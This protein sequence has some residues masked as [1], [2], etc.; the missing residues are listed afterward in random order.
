[1]STSE[2]SECGKVVSS[3]FTECG[4]ENV[5]I[6]CLTVDHFQCHG[7]DGF[8]KDEDCVTDRNGNQ[9][10]EDCYKQNFVQCYWCDKELDRNDAWEDPDGDPACES[11]RDRRYTLCSGCGDWIH[12]DHTNVS[13]YGD[14]FCRDCYGERYI[15]CESC[16]CEISTDDVCD[17]GLCSGCYESQNNGIHSYSYKPR[18]VFFKC[19]GEKTNRFFGVELEIENVDGGDEHKEAL[20]GLEH[21][22][23]YKHD[24][25]LDAGFEVV[26]H[27]FTWKWMQKNRDRLDPIFNLKKYGYRSW[28]TDTCGM[29]VHVTKRSISNLTLYRLLKLFTNH[30][31]WILAV[32][33]RTRSNLDNWAAIEFDSPL[34]SIARRKND[35]GNRHRAINL[36]PEDTIEFRIF[37]GTLNKESFMANLEFVHTVLEYCE[38]AS[39][40]DVCPNGY[41]EFI[42]KKKKKQMA[43]VLCGNCDEDE[44]E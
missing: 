33:R 30:P 12:L 24:G 28:N 15:S 9:Y 22:I 31:S 23:Y 11:C 4:L 32:S 20:C 2:C 27:P 21:F 19:P 10:C 25:S 35:S 7:C 17:D 44:D 1:M 26:T 29:H 39:Y 40:K 13:E 14:V 8:F 5:C 38:Q 3:L 18:P 16:G 6:D 34:S 37:R 43:T 36:C 42:G 41:I